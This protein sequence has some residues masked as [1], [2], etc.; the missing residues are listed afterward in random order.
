MPG[1]A[2]LML[3]STEIGTMARVRELGARAD[4]LLRPEVYRFS[5][6][7]VKAFDRLIEAGYANARDELAKWMQ[8]RAT[9]ER[10]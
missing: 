3:K 1:L 8:A 10:D 6:M 7:N 5:M 4:L 2:T 9:P